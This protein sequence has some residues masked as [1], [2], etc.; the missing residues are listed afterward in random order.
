MAEKHQHSSEDGLK[1]LALIM[2]VTCVR[3]TIIEDYHTDGKLNDKEMKAFNKE[4][5]NKLYTFLT[6]MFGAPSPER[7]EF[8][9]MAEIFVP[10][11]WDEPDLDEDTMLGVDIALG[12]KK[13]P[14]L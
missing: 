2:A 11:N 13:H 3:N 12:K 4:V 8:L 7:N 14:K 10:H 9:R 6:F 1:R 5:A